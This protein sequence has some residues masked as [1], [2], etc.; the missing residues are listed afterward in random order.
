MSA[1]AAPDG[2]DPEGSESQ[3]QRE[4]ADRPYVESPIIMATV[5][6][7]APFVFT[8]GAFVMFHGADSAGGGFQGGVIVGTVILM[9]AIAFGVEPTR[10]WLSASLLTT[11]VVVGVALFM[12]IGLTALAFGGAFLEYTAIPV[13][14]A[15]KYGI[16]LVEVGIGIVVSGAVVG[17]F[18]GLASGH[19]GDDAEAES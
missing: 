16:E 15:S 2:D 12:G 5:R 3:R 13:H 17:L 9:V 19:A 4:R 14:H 10:D 1:V 18:F 11:L 7:V 6:I 8:L